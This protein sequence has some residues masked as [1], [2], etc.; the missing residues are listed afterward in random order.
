MLKISNTPINP[1]WYRTLK[2]IIRAEKPDIINS[3]QPVPFIG[4]LAAFLAGNIPFVLTYHQGTMR[5]NQV[6]SD[7]L[8]FL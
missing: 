7:I 8:I 2:S 1:L 3:H 5:K 4:D 6:L